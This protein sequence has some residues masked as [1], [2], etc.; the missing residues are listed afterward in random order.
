MHHDSASRA[1]PARLGRCMVCQERWVRPVPKRLL[2]LGGHC[3]HPCL[4]LLFSDQVQ[5]G[6][7]RSVIR[8]S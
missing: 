3:F 8:C 6:N 7:F 2:L 4:L 5:L 1:L